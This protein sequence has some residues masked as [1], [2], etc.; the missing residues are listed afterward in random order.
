MSRKNRRIQTPQQ[1][2]RYKSRRLEELNAA[3]YNNGKAIDEGS[4]RKVWTKHDLLTIR[5]LTPPQE[6]MVHGY[7]NGYDVCGFGTAGTGKAQP[8]YSKI[9]TPSG[10][11]TMGEMSMGDIVLT[12]EGKHSTVIGIFPQGKKD[13][14]E[15]TFSDG[16]KTRGCAEHLWE[17][18][19]PKSKTWRNG[20]EK[21]VINTLELIEWLDIKKNNPTKVQNVSID[22]IEPIEYNIK[23]FDIH[24]YVLGVILGDGS[25]ISTTPTI[26]SPDKEIIDL[27]KEFLIEGYQINQYNSSNITYSIVQQKHTN[28]ENSYTT[29]LKNYG[30]HGTKSYEKF[31]PEEYK[32]GSIEQRLML[33]NGLFDTDGT[34]GKKCKDVSYCTTSKKMAHDIQEILWSL[35]AKC[36]IDEK[37]CKYVDKNGER[38][39]TGRIGYTLRVSY[40]K[41]KDLFYLPRKKELCADKYES[42]QLRR[43]VR[44]IELVS[45]EEAQC[46]MIDDDKHLYITDDYIITHNTLIALYLAFLDILDEKTPRKKIIIIRSIVPT[47]NPGFLPG[48]IAEKISPHEAAYPPLFRK[49]FGKSSTYNDMKDVGL[50]EFNSTCFV[51]GTTIDDAIIIFDEATNTTLEEFDSVV[52]RRGKNTKVFVLGDLRQNDLANT[53]EKS[54]FAEALRIM[55]TTGDYAMVKFTVHD[56]VRSA[57]VKNWILARESLGI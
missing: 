28:N 52:T 18:Y 14:Y 48:T 50:V 34:V 5:T 17:C 45:N 10:W 41:P 21:K 29:F 38:I 54:G 27:M 33:I 46:I 42:K 22:L 6:D 56:V 3:L 16:A 2:K 30:L 15:V 57:A 36:S 55:E 4:Q 24:P 39:V 44:N 11:K 12:P 47:R 19:V 20:S 49:L 13:I 51:R 8:L 53:K 1:P 9:M 26:T 32:F 40:K 31:I 35:G 25:I 43:Y 23:K 7:L 37:P